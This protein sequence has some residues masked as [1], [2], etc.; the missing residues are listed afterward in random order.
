MKLTDKTLEESH[1]DQLLATRDL[2]ISAHVAAARRVSHG[3]ADREAREKARA[4]CADMWNQRFGFVDR[5]VVV[6]YLDALDL[7]NAAARG[8][9]GGE[10]S[11][12][13]IGV[14]AQL[15]AAEAALRRAAGR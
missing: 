14:D 11:P 5:I 1:L 3:R 10:R 7:W 13:L 2:T 6:A 12:C 8:L 15:R 9:P 4:W